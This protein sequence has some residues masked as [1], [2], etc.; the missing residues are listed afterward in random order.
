MTRLEIRPEIVDINGSQR[1]HDHQESVMHVTARS[2][3]VAR[4]A[5][6]GLAAT[7]E[8]SNTS[9]TWHAAGDDVRM[10]RVKLPRSDWS[11]ERSGTSANREHVEDV[12]YST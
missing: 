9:V 10:C 4:A 8:N 6:C 12:M 7:R 1:R 3:R 5:R 2:P 11:Q